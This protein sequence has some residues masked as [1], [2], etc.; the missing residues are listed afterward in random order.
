MTFEELAV[1][2]VN[3]LELVKKEG[4]IGLKNFASAHK[5]NLGSTQRHA[6]D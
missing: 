6:T 2:R 5:G 1:L 3:L 4:V